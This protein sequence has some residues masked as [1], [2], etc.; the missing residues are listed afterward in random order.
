MF[1]PLLRSN[2]TQPVG[3]PMPAIHH[4]RNATSRLR[5]RFVGT[6]LAEYPLACSHVKVVSSDLLR[7]GT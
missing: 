1:T 4:A 5:R 3:R 7:T 6:V 2:A